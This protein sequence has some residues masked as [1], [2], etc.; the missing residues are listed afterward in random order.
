VGSALLTAAACGGAEGSAILPGDYFTDL[1]RIS[2]NAHIQE[3]GLARELTRRLE[4]Q[5]G[6]ERLNTVVVYVEQSARLYEDV[7]DALDALEPAD[8]MEGAHQG[9]LD[10]WAAQLELVLQV[11]DAGFQAAPRYLEALEAAVFEDA[12][13][14]TRA[15]CQD[16]QEAAAGLGRELDLACD[17]RPA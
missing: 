3:R 8:G 1:A 6:G 7:V 13:S 16:A 9:Y 12:A 10:A 4:R 5:G 2:Q 17:G 14:T 11:R 15:R